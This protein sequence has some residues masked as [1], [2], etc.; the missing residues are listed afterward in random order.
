M[1]LPISFQPLYM[2][3]VWGGRKFA[4]LYNRQLPDQQP[5]G[6]SWE[7]SDRENEQSVVTSEN[8]AGL[9]LN[10]LWKNHQKTIFGDDMPRTERFPLLIKILDASQDLSIQVHPPASIA[11]ELGGDPKTE[12]WY[13][14]GADP[15]TKIYIG[16]KRNTDKQKFQQAI[17]QGTVEDFVHSLEPKSGD[18][19]HIE[20]GRLH[21]IGAGSLIYEIQQNSDTTY[22]V[23]DWNRVGLDGK[24]RQLH[25]TE[26]MQCIDFE[27]IEPS[28]DIAKDDV[29]ASC[30]YYNV[31]K[32]TL[33]KNSTFTQPDSS[34]FAIISLI[35]G[36]MTDQAG[37]GYQKGD[38]FL[39]P[40]NS[41]PLTCQ[42]TTELLIT[43]LP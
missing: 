30:S 43:T 28:M 23:F 8:Y 1:M 24:P 10:D 37:N 17:Q 32:R 11:K 16:L 14:A 39:L 21:A 20:S 13:I 41:A 5:Y 34:R 33:E 38:F 42:T 2:Q 26:A 18:S 36:E 15:Q 25:K 9:T 22:R 6:E 27:D 40:A 4:T 35:E 3:R 19:I 29:L 31:K 7:I 12:M